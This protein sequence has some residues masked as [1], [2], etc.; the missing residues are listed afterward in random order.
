[1]SPFRAGS[2]TM[3]NWFIQL[4]LLWIT[5]TLWHD[6]YTSHILTFWNLIYGI[7]I[8]WNMKVHSYIC[9]QW[10]NSQ[11]IYHVHMLYVYEEFCIISTNLHRICKCPK[12]LF[13]SLVNDDEEPTIL[14]TITLDIWFHNHH[15]H[16]SNFH[17]VFF[18]RE[19]FLL[20]LCFVY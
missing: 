10:Q 12:C 6:I 16:L 7:I 5:M 15:N 11:Y 9:R 14:R 17:L 19:E 8:Y 2:N 1:M 3:L 20:L 13:T 18:C 4:D